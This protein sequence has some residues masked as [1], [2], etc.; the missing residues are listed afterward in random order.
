MPN[1]VWVGIL[2]IS[3]ATAAKIAQRGITEFDIQDAVVARVLPFTWHY[4]STRGWR[5]IVEVIIRHKR[6]LIV[7]YPKREDPFGEAWNLGSAY[8]IDK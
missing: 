5:V 8:E 7:L 2:S 3:S 1:S 4:H 6:F